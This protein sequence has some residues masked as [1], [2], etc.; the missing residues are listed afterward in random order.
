MLLINDLT[1]LVAVNVCDGMTGY[2]QTGPDGYIIE[3]VI[4]EFL[5]IESEH[6]VMKVP[7]IARN[8]S[9]EKDEITRM[10]REVVGILTYQIFSNYLA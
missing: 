7:P 2:I 1:S 5:D 9:V 8:E 10:K 4:G 6:V 3:P